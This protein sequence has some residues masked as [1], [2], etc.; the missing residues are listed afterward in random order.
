M[1]PTREK[2]Y[3]RVRKLIGGWETGT[4]IV[5]IFMLVLE[6]G[7]KGI[8]LALLKNRM[9]DGVRVKRKLA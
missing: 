2:N 1:T 9:V 7:E 3:S 6:K 4:T 5:P 8:T